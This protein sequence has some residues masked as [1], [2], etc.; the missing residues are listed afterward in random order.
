[1]TNEI[2]QPFQLNSAGGIAMTS[3]PNV[4]AQQHIVSLIST[5]PTER[6]MLPSY[7]T[8]VKGAVFSPGSQFV[9]GMLQ[10]EISR[11][12][13]VFEPNITVNSIN[14]VSTGDP[15]DP[16]QVTMDWS[17][18]NIQTGNSSGLQTATILVG[19][20]VVQNGTIVP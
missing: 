13:E 20:T 12:M 11:A 10:Q 16:A 9:T 17:I 18:N 6:V 8:G 2:L 19:G 7:G 4:Q 3:D 15:E 5:S 14:V 1:M